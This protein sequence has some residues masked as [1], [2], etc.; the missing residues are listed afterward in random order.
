MTIDAQLLIKSE[1]N[2]W[3]YF[4]RCDK[5]QHFIVPKSS[6]CYFLWVSPLKNQELSY[7]KIL[8]IYSQLFPPFMQSRL[9]ILAEKRTVLKICTHSFSL[10][11]KRGKKKKSDPVNLLKLFKHGRSRVTQPA[12]VAKWVQSEKLF[13][14]HYNLT[15]LTHNVRFVFCFFFF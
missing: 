6:P 9:L 1:Q 4:F 11:L 2:Q 8:Y 14:W 10:L 5:T 15:I 7:R 12:S 3:N 13:Q